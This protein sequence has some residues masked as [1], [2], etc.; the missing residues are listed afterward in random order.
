LVQAE[1]WPWQFMEIWLEVEQKLRVFRQA[2][3]SGRIT[4]QWPVGEAAQRG[5][6]A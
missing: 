6:D 4:D 5:R 3:P 2:V 1:A